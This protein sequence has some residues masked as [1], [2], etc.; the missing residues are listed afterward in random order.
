MR[1]PIW[2]PPVLPPTRLPVDEER[3]RAVTDD[4]VISPP[5]SE[6][7]LTSAEALADAEDAMSD[8]ADAV[9]PPVA[10]TEP[11]VGYANELPSAAPSGGAETAAPTAP[12]WPGTTTLIANARAEAPVASAPDE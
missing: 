2:E 6:S 12:D 4:A 11:S 1:L 8:C 3:A 9:S 5:K 10:A 7:E